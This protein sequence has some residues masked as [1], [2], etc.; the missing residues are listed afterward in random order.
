MKFL[1]IIMSVITSVI[2]VAFIISFCI[3]IFGQS[4]NRFFL[5]LFICN[6]ALL[7][8]SLGLLTIIFCGEESDKNNKLFKAYIDVSERVLPLTK[9]NHNN[10][11]N[12]AKTSQTM[13]QSPGTQPIH[14]S[15]LNKQLK[16]IR[17]IFKSYANALADI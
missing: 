8:L 9:G 17:E 16:S 2:V 7:G 13:A 3:I 14:N 12:V 6:T 11:Q 15:Y 4:D 1:K 10:N 5:I